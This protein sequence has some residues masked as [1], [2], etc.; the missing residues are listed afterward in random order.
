MLYIVLIDRVTFIVFVS[1]NLIECY[2]QNS[3]TSLSTESMFET[4][5]FD[6]SSIDSSWMFLCEF[7]LTFIDTM[8]K[9]KRK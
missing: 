1:Q 2:L 9:I 8:Q 5:W 6:E 4:N 7:V 3:E